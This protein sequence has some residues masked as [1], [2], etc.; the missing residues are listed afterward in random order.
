MR[1]RLGRFTAH[2]IPLGGPDMDAVWLRPH[3]QCV[4]ALAARLPLLG[5]DVTSSGL[6]GA[7]L[8]VP[9]ASRLGLRCWY[10]LLLVQLCHP[11]PPLCLCDCSA[12]P[13]A[14]LCPS[15]CLAALP[16]AAR[17]CC[18]RCYA[19]CCA[20]CCAVWCACCCCCALCRARCIRAA[21][22]A[23]SVECHDRLCTY[24]CARCY[25]RHYARLSARCCCSGSGSCS[26][27][28]IFSPGWGW[29]ARSCAPFVTPEVRGR[30]RPSAK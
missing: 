22:S 21:V 15:L 16:D 8:H 12:S 24:Y 18:A 26:G 28:A 20:R 5:E 1:L 9:I 10:L 19:R 6:G 7:I 17:P 2:R 25:A 13:H 30:E 27:S 14:L 23:N 11:R 4:V 3:R 29:C